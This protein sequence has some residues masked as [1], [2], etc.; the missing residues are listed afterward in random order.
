[1]TREEL[2][3]AIGQVEESRLAR[4]EL[5]VQAPEKGKR[6]I[7]RNLLVAAII[8]SMLG[9]TACAV[10][11][12]VLFDS[13]QEMIAAVFGDQTGFDH[14]GITVA[15][16][17][18]K[19]EYPYE[20]PAYDRVPADTKVVEAVTPYVSPVGKSINFHG[21]TLTVDSYL[22]DSTTQCG[23]VTYLLNYPDGVPEYWVGE[24]GRCDLAGEPEVRATVNQYGWGYIIQEKTTDTVLALRYYFKYDRWHEDGEELYLGLHYQAPGTDFASLSERCREEVRAEYTR[25]E[26]IAAAIAYAGEEY[27]ESF[28]EMFK[29]YKEDWKGEAAYSLLLEKRTQEQW[30][31]GEDSEKIILD[32]SRSSELGCVSLGNGGAFVS[33]ISLQIEAKKIDF[34]LHKPEPRPDVEIMDVLSMVDVDSLIVRFT[35]GTEYVIVDQGVENLVFWRCSPSNDTPYEDL[36][37]NENTQ[38]TV[39]FNRVIDVDKVEA[40]I[41]NGIEIKAD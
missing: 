2:F 37:K 26:A 20:I 36:I 10:V 7:F 22:Y 21:V 29:G 28:A 15:V 5:S 14:K 8:M 11:G 38:M 13:P 4:S 27:F 35:D 18:E 30:D 23:V 9:L 31:D 24:D 1:M 34:L 39:M 3:F 25:D 12:Y 32:V 19:P 16:D 40:I 33:P 41:V 6:H 17:P